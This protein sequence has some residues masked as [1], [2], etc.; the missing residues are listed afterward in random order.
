[1]RRFNHSLEQL[2]IVQQQAADTRYRVVL[3]PPLNSLGKSLSIQAERSTSH[4]TAQPPDDTRCVE[5]GPADTGATKALW[6]GI[7]YARAL[8]AHHT[9]PAQKRVMELGLEK[10]WL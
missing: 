6:Y 10:T 9:V 3:A 2:P 4:A 8:G 7:D 5:N 1:M